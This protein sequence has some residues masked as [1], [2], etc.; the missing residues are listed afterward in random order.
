MLAVWSR[1]ARRPVR[2]ASRHRR[3]ESERIA[4][5]Q[6]PP[7]G[8]G[9]NPYAELLYGALADHGI[10]R[11]P[12]PGLTIGALWRSRRTIAI[13]HF[14]W[15]PE[16]S[17]APSL[18]ELRMREP[19]RRVQAT[20]ELCRFALCLLFARLLGYR[21]VWTVHEVPPARHSR[22]DRAGQALLVRA[23][24]VILA[25]D[26]AVADRLSEERGRP[27]PIEIVKHG[28]F[29]GV[30]AVNRS[31][32]D[33]RAEL[34][35]PATA[36]VFLCFGQMRSDKEI[37]FLLDAFAA[38]DLPDAYLVIAGAPNHEPSR[39]RVQAAASRDGRIRAI[40]ERVP[41]E[42]VGELFAM[43]DAFVLARNQVWTSGSL[44]LSLSFGLPV[45]A[46]RLSPVIELL[47]DDETGWLF[48]PGDLTSLTRMLRRAALDRPEAARKR[49]MARIRGEELPGWSEVARRT[50]WVLG[51]DLAPLPESPLDLPVVPDRS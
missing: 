39:R 45:V 33:V 26:R 3:R 6:L 17:Y 13:L 21:I 47:G 22:I 16:L 46:A 30:Y 11:A 48:T 31:R 36:I 25:H 51:P 8:L 35:I 38:A 2:R 29:K 5:A 18:V 50:A 14:H 28:T 42:R 49:R 4:L 40:L 41:P 37:P 12:F 27:L 10:P 32:E 9:P 24:S 44:I 34:R 23:S 7:P 20:A 43:A 15:R 1:G 19:R